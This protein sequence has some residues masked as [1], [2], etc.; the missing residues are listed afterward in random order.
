[1]EREQCCRHGPVYAHGDTAGLY[2]IAYECTYPSG[3]HRLRP[4]SSLTVDW[5]K[6]RI[7]GIYGDPLSLLPEST[8]QLQLSSGKNVCHYTMLGMLLHFPF[9]VIWD[10]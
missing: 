2:S 10:R 4:C 5:Q 3:I 8:F 7:H 1:M 6:G 9:N